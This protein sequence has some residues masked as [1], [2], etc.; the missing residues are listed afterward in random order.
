MIPQDLQ[1]MTTQA[2]SAHITKRHGIELRQHAPA[3][4]AMRDTERMQRF[5]GVAL[6]LAAIVRW[7]GKDAQAIRGELNRRL[8]S[9]DV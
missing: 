1:G 7:T 5:E 2:I 9:G 3:L 8:R 6:F 4:A